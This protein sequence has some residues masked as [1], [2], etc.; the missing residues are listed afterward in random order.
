MAT[1]AGVPCP[2][3][4]SPLPGEG[5]ECPT[6]GLPRELWP[7]PGEGKG[8]G[9]PM[10]GLF[11]D[12]MKELEGLENPAAT[13]APSGTGDVAGKTP[14]APPSPTAPTA[15]SGDDGRTLPAA[16]TAPST[17]SPTVEVEKPGEEASLPA[18]P[19]AAPTVTHRPSYH[20]E[21]VEV[22]P[23][24]SD[25]GLPL[26]AMLD[27]VSGQIQIGKRAGFDMNFFGP[28]AAR[29]VGLV[30][31]G[32]AIEARKSL[33]SLRSDLYQFLARHFAGKVEQLQV[34]MERMQVFLRV[35]QAES[36][37]ERS[38]AALKAGDFAKAQVELRRLEGEITRL[39]E[40]LGSMGE[41]LE[42]VDL[43]TQEVERMG[44]DSTPA[45]LIQ[46]RAMEAARA[47]DRKKAEGLLTNA[48]AMLLDTLAPLMGQELVQ[49]TEKLKAQ[50]AKGRDIRAAVQIVRRIT[51]DIKSRNYT[52]ALSA[53]NRLR[54]EISAT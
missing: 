54:E 41:T 13:P 52:Q 5:P 48:S 22:A 3:C 31:A 34:K 32:D 4:K 2:V 9:G 33:V 18:S 20:V 40:D 14:S 10:D 26:P 38:R 53:L 6:C 28:L 42:Q 49:L 29:A 21:A 8:G 25:E 35:D 23:Q 46:G 7:V 36:H 12:L 51:V 24:P 39:E 19:P 44:G 17:V 37:V 27:E 43:L 47:G 50:R 11:G 45:L 1:S 15:A 30:R 16:A